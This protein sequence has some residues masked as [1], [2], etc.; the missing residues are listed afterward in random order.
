M[1]SV[2]KRGNSYVIRYTYRDEHG[3]S[4][5]G[6]E[7]RKTAKEAKERKLEIETALL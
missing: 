6:W 1:A 3:Q 4:R 2:T 7:S 5:S